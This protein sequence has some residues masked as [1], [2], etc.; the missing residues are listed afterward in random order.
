MKEKIEQMLHPFESNKDK[1]EQPSNI[2]FE[3]N[4]LV[5]INS[6]IMNSAKLIQHLLYVVYSLKLS[7]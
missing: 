1:K 3:A 7:K 4:L 6:I 2:H 5:Q